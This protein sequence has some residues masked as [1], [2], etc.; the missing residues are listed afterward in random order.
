MTG[1]RSASAPG[2]RGRGTAVFLRPTGEAELRALVREFIADNVTRPALLESS[3][4]D[5]EIAQAYAS[6]RSAL[7]T[8]SSRVRGRLLMEGFMSGL[9]AAGSWLV[10]VGTSAGQAVVDGYN[11]IK[12]L[13]KD[14]LDAAGKILTKILRE[15]PKGEA[16]FEMLKDFSDDVIEKIVEYAQ[17]AAGELA[18]WLT[19]SKDVIITRTF[20]SVSDPGVKDR[21]K[22]F[23]KE[24]YANVKEQAKEQVDAFKEFF[25][26]LLDNPV[27]AAKKL[28]SLLAGLGRGFWS[29]IARRIIVI[30][31]KYSASARTK[32]R[33]AILQFDLFKGN[34]GLFIMRLISI[35]TFDTAGDKSAD[36]VIGSAVGLYNAAKMIGGA[37]GF[38]RNDRLLIDV[39][40][41]VVK[42]LISGENSI[43]LAVRSKMGDPTAITKLIKNGIGLAFAAL[44]KIVATQ[45]EKWIQS[46][47]LDPEKGTGKGIMTGLETMFSV[48][49]GN[50]QSAAGVG[51]SRIRGVRGQRAPR[52]PY[53]SS[54]GMILRR[55]HN[56][57]PDMRITES[58]LRRIIRQEVGRLQEKLGPYLPPKSPVDPADTVFARIPREHVE[59]A[60][61]PQLFQ[62]FIIRNNLRDVDYLSVWEQG[63][64]FQL[65]AQEDEGPMIVGSRAAVKNALAMI[66]RAHGRQFV[67]EGEP[68]PPLTRIELRPVRGSALDIIRFRRE[69]E[70]RGRV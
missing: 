64:E 42:G 45:V 62:N 24:A 37:I 31:F 56:G 54:A 69:D 30:I 59:A 28:M 49:T 67:R 34:K 29:E 17:E 48:A 1:Y 13:G 32:I 39:I 19:D 66:Q 51:E 33:D 65:D 44:K 68:L 53:I 55:H 57:E 50:A 70:L 11:D 35:L 6:G 2:H 21:I 22:E 25:K 41:D 43:E 58:Q 18:K 46:A 4:G 52:G 7:L 27:S 47:G 16:L 38:D 60:H 40:P 15:I 23:A 63:G 26:L 20:E 10:S 8:E 12:R 9:A 36:K 5:W 61:G 14:A 3:M